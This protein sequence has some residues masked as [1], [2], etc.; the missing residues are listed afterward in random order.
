[1]TSKPD[2]QGAP[3]P[4]T[5][6]EKCLEGHRPGKSVSIGTVL[7]RFWAL[8]RYARRVTVDRVA[9]IVRRVGKAKDHQAAR[10][11]RILVKL[12]KPARARLDEDTQRR[13]EVF[14]V[15]LRE[16]SSCRAGAKDDQVL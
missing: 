15:A 8:A 6:R 5:D 1:M 12:I 2:G 16:R 3:A 10:L 7:R 14:A 4:A 9:S 13:D 11:L